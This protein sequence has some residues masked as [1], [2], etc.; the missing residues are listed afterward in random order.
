MRAKQ[1]FYACGGI[2]L[3]VIAYSIGS[4]RA[5]ADFEFAPRPILGMDIA[6]PASRTILAANGTVWTIYTDAE[7]VPSW[8]QSQDTNPIPP[9]SLTEI[10]FW[11][12]DFVVTKDGHG[13]VKELGQW[14]DTGVLP[15]S[16]VS[17]NQATWGQAK[18]NYRK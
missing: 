12:R 2:L 18:D 15:V 7:H 1:F 16:P 11:S 17:A 10:A 9:V 14:A 4:H 3:L 6:F 5:L 8:Q 13:W